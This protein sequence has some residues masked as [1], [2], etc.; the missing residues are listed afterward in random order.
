MAAIRTYDEIRNIYVNSPAAQ[1]RALP[2]DPSQRLDAEMEVSRLQEAY[3][4]QNEIL[5]L[6]IRVNNNAVMFTYI[7]TDNS[8]W[9]VNNPN[10]PT[11]AQLISDNIT[12]SAAVNTPT[13]AEEQ[14]APAPSLPPEAPSPD[15]TEYS[16]LFDYTQR[17]QGFGAN[18]EFAAKWRYKFSLPIERVPGV[19]DVGGQLGRIVDAARGKELTANNSSLMIAMAK[20][21]FGLGSVSQVTPEFDAAL[22]SAIM[23]FQ[24][25]NRDEIYEAGNYSVEPD[26]LRNVPVLSA[27]E[28]VQFDID[29]PQ[30]YLAERGRI[31]TP[32]YTVMVQQ[33]FLA[34]ARRFLSD[35]DI[36]RMFTQA[37]SPD[38]VIN[39]FERKTERQESP[40]IGTKYI[41][42]TYVSKI[43]KVGR[44]EGEGLTLLEKTAMFRQAVKK[45][46]DFYGKKKTWTIYGNTEDQLR[47]TG[48][49]DSILNKDLG[50]DVKLHEEIL[51]YQT[52]LPADGSFSQDQFFDFTVEE[53]RFNDQISAPEVDVLYGQELK[54]NTKN[55][56][57]ARIKS[58]NHPNL[59]P[60][61][62]YT[63]S[64]QIRR[65]IFDLIPGRNSSH[66]GGTQD[67][68]DP[69]TYRRW[70]NR[71][72]AAKEKWDEF[73]GKVEDLEIP[74]M[75]DLEEGFDKWKDAQQRKMEAWAEDQL[76][77]AWDSALAGDNVAYDDAL[78]EQRAADEQRRREAQQF[79]ISVKIKLRGLKAKI[80]DISK[81]MKKHQPDLIKFKEKNTT[82][83]PF[84]PLFPDVSLDSES[85]R[86][87]QF[88]PKLENFLRINGYSLE[89]TSKDAQIQVEFLPVLKDMAMPRPPA[90]PNPDVSGPNTITVNTQVGYEILSVSYIS[91]P[92][93][94]VL[95][96]NAGQEEFLDTPWI[97]PTT[98]AY[99]MQTD[100]IHSTI[101]SRKTACEEYNI[102][103]GA[104]LFLTK[105][106]YP[107]VQA[108]FKKERND[109]ALMGIK[110]GFNDKSLL[111]TAQS[112]EQAQALLQENWKALKETSFFEQKGKVITNDMVMP[113]LGEFLCDIEAIYKKFFDDWNF[114]Y[115]MC[116]YLKCF[117][118]LGPWNFDFRW[119]LPSIPK[120]PTFDPLSFVLPQIRIK[121]IEM[122]MAFLCR[123]LK[124]ILKT[125]A[126]PDCSDLL[127]FGMAQLSALNEMNKDNPYANAKQKATLLE[128]TSETL[129]G[130]GLSPD[131]LATESELSISK[132]LDSIS[133]V[134]SPKELC[135]L[136]QG[137]STDEVAEIALRVAQAGEY[138][139]LSTILVSIS[140]I[141]SFFETLGTNV[142]PYLCDRINE[143]DSISFAGELCAD[144]ESLSPREIAESHT[145]S[146]EELAQ[147]L[148]KLAK[149]KEVFDQ[150]IA[151]G[152][153]SSLLPDSLSPDNAEENGLSGPYNNSL[154]DEKASQAISAFLEGVKTLYS[155]EIKTLVERFITE[156]T[157]L[158]KL[159]DPGFNGYK[160]ARFTYYNR[161]LISLSNEEEKVHHLG[162]ME[163]LRSIL[164]G[165]QFQ[166]AIALGYNMDTMEFIPF[167][168]AEVL[169]EDLGEFID[170]AYEYVVSYIQ[171]F[172]E[173]ELEI[174]TE[175]KKILSRD[176]STVTRIFPGGPQYLR[177]LHVRAVTDL[178]TAT[179]DSE[180]NVVDSDSNVPSSVSVGYS[181][182][183]FLDTAVKDCYEYSFKMSYD[184]KP[185]KYFSKVYKESLPEVY[186]TYRKEHL[187]VNSD[188][189]RDKLLRPGG[190]SSLL[191]ERLSQLSEDK[192][193][194]NTL[195]VYAEGEENIIPMFQGY[196]EDLPREEI[197]EL[198]E[199]VMEDLE[200]PLSGLIVGF[201]VAALAAGSSTVQKTKF[202][203]L[204]ASVSDS[205][206][207]EISDITKN[208]KYFNLEELQNFES[209]IA[210]RYFRNT[211]SDGTNC[212]VENPRALKLDKIIQK[213]LSLYRD[214]ANK[215][216][217]EPFEEDFEG[218]GPFELAMVES[219]FSLYV[220][221]VCFEMSLK[222]IFML[223]NYGVERMFDQ[224]FVMDYVVESVLSDFASLPLTQKDRR[225]IM[226]RIGQITNIEDPTQSLRAL[227]VKCLG[228]S[229]IKD[230]ID[231]IFLNDHSSYKE[232]FYNDLV[233]NMSDIPSM[234]DAPLLKTTSLPDDVP[235]APPYFNLYDKFNFDGYSPE[236]VAKKTNSG[237]FWVEKF[238]KVEDMPRILQLAS[239]IPRILAQSI[240]GGRADWF[241]TE[242]QIK[243][244]S[245]KYNDY[246]SP[247][248]LSQFLFGTSSRELAG[249]DAGSILELKYTETL[250]L[251]MIYDFY[252]RQDVSPRGMAFGNSYAR[253]HGSKAYRLMALIG[254]SQ[255]TRALVREGVVD[256]N[257]PGI[258]LENPQFRELR[259]SQIG[260]GRRVGP[261][262]EPEDLNISDIDGAYR[263]GDVTRQQISERIKKVYNYVNGRMASGAT[264]M[265]TLNMT[266][267]LG[268]E[269]QSSH[270]ILDWIAFADRSFPEGW[271]EDLFL[272][273]NFE[274]LQDLLGTTNEDMAEFSTISE[275]RRIQIL[276]DCL[277][278]FVEIANNWPRN[279]V[280]GLMFPPRSITPVR[281][282]GENLVVNNQTDTLFHDIS[283][284]GKNLSYY[285]SW[286][287]PILSHWS[288]I[289]V[290]IPW[291]TSN[292]AGKAISLRS[293]RTHD[294]M[295]VPV[296]QDLLGVVNSFGT[297]PMY[298]RYTTPQYVS[299]GGT[300][301]QDRVLDYYTSRV[302][303]SAAAVGTSPLQEQNRE[304]LGYLD[305]RIR[306]R[307]DL[308]ED[309]VIQLTQVQNSI[310]SMLNDNLS[311]GTRLM[312]GVRARRGEVNR[313]VSDMGNLAEDQPVG[314]KVL[315]E[316]TPE[317]VFGDVVY[318][319]ESSSIGLTSDPSI[320]TRKRAFVGYVD[321][322]D[323]MTS[324]GVLNR[325]SLFFT[326]ANSALVT[327]S[328][329]R[330][331][332]RRDLDDLLS[333]DGLV[334][335]TG[336][337]NN[338][339]EKVKN[340][341]VYSIP[342][343]EK[344]MKVECLPELFDSLDIGAD[345]YQV[346]D[347]DSEF[348]N[349]YRRGFV[350][351]TLFEEHY[352][353]SLIDAL[354]SL[355]KPHAPNARRLR[356]VSEYDDYDAEFMKIHRVVFDLLFPIDRYAA[357]HFLQ[358]V[359]ILSNDG[360][361]KTL[362]GAT[363]TLIISLIDQIVNLKTPEASAMDNAEAAKGPFGIDLSISNLMQMLIDM[364]RELSKIA[365]RTTIREI[366]R[367]VDPT[368]KDMRKG[369]L[370]DPCSMK[371]GL[372][373]KLT[374]PGKVDGDGN[375][376]WDSIDRGFADVNG[377]KAYIPV[378]RFAGDLT[379]AI[380]NLDYQQS[381]E[382]VEMV[383]GIVK[384]KSKRYGYPQTF[385]TNW[386]LS[387]GEIPM[388]AH[389]YLKKNN[390]C[391]DQDCETKENIQPA[392]LCE[393]EPGEQ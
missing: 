65:D 15:A 292:D 121:L 373:K 200:D 214:Y 194:L 37:S 300:S 112:I 369:Y 209:E 336:E 144:D 226:D 24:D 223:S 352:K 139:V 257:P 111:T 389:K 233:N 244:N 251:K 358:N 243:T 157:T 284:F 132:F 114:N 295:S 268:Y 391:E 79:P 229:D 206:N 36:Q 159:G 30:G 64:I 43:T 364:I 119:S 96:L 3:L 56:V 110:L 115:L 154:H 148:D 22:E 113:K 231:T 314:E 175:L 280:E 109:K 207:Y 341:I 240:P 149:K 236:L 17:M 129:E 116:D 310:I 365:M 20:Y 255:S 366:V 298:R 338:L 25:T 94:A 242:F 41:N 265:K 187:D 303:G 136:L 308:S 88:L 258:V 355:H 166:E 158:P 45:V 386:A 69:E 105:F 343:D 192:S 55:I 47:T 388:E 331:R 256:L 60:N 170:K 323:L 370:E 58:I 150:I 196:V 317:M 151:D 185:D 246:M 264:D 130:M 273:S 184:S 48:A 99:F 167:R 174:K 61:S 50:K 213:M 253:C 211:E 281:Q 289:D 225:S 342:L 66:I 11:T 118:T 178:A 137:E 98:I 186:K 93:D 123:F 299:L 368:Y 165:S 248:E 387:I 203:P 237:H 238:Y 202:S 26:F 125:L 18:E 46:F 38:D 75:S 262:I 128:K 92:G 141:R 312:F 320:F 83:S 266:G 235:A 14:Q 276:G 180:I 52:R 252:S 44:P 269:Y 34:S 103:P 302:L 393:D 173:A 19:N 155:I 381:R 361:T 8:A 67:L 182:L 117:P 376:R 315:H 161:Q 127:K 39:A 97:Y 104:I 219:M 68:S 290:G 340:S 51:K 84:P 188:I 16:I 40:T 122:I 143:I 9:A 120:M 216:E 319:R 346:Q 101:G 217:H 234:E 145:S 259:L 4:L 49:A 90:G 311:I 250:F 106:H 241:E 282:P 390:E 78:R 177:R 375:S 351:T 254:M 335:T 183:P 189:H 232:K 329:A 28:D 304:K 5:R 179:E 42:Y 208:S 271:E 384:G 205:L 153:F 124:N 168:G 87:I 146:S 176:Q 76:G 74:S 245:D 344:T 89:V 212:F 249:N 305:T 54:S 318:D 172:T 63:M 62:V 371:S 218:P 337:Y 215:P 126:L 190:F 142:D 325:E 131:V 23:N 1:Q 72:K 349:L 277:T 261:S 383:E 163:P 193:N 59:R 107:S 227:V 380:Y 274:W 102:G 270:A 288:S 169:P 324:E 392:G 230:L 286:D 135:S 201:V 345:F 181:E 294:D 21:F 296:D 239:S 57:F 35:R 347:E 220:T 133:L 350:Q 326:E 263:N 32:T 12:A 210:T 73:R 10:D 81:E 222:G 339:N 221:M 91:K 316:I 379:R 29:L 198:F 31:G 77:N 71:G 160:H 382:V 327:I 138:S 85:S 134:L 360:E 2:S 267:E 321:P 297:L 197:T 279:E 147:E 156:T 328:T 334:G 313:G 293:W 287:S 348:N 377:C 385:L 309:L 224:A 272:V 306:E 357:N 191:T 260:E 140:D 301:L 53:K 374:G 228:D 164:F 95:P 152:D 332:N 354:L 330:I 278:Y 7:D 86:L 367:V 362:L 80:E 378:N 100:P 372:V 307:Y 33:G 285:Y 204:Y 70:Y 171:E 283:S 27:L 291:E 356:T 363:K 13:P 333:S 162:K 199:S 322:V 6:D 359:Q 275:S 195:N 82:K 353:D 247:R 108:N